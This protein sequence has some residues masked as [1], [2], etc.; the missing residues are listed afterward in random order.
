[1]MQHVWPTVIHA[2]SVVSFVLLVLVVYGGFVWVTLRWLIKRFRMN[3]PEDNDNDLQYTPVHAVD[4]AAQT[5]ATVVPL[6]R[7][8]NRTIGRVFDYSSITVDLRGGV[9]SFGGS[10]THRELPEDDARDILDMIA[11]ALMIRAGG[12]VTISR[13]E[14]NN[15]A[16]ACAEYDLDPETGEILFRIER[17]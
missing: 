8:R 4:S 12:S 10:M 1:M 14:M 5:T 7:N 11:K 15:A 13:D 16:L 2:L 3:F 17:Q 9:Q 6:V